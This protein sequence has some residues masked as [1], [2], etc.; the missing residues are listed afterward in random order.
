M[1]VNHNWFL[2]YT[3]D[4]KGHLIVDTEQ[5][6]QLLQRVNASKDYE[7]IADEIERLRDKKQSLSVED[8]EREGDLAWYNKLSDL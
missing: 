1:Q 6:E 2:G 3:K 7:D 4:E 8:S 5:A